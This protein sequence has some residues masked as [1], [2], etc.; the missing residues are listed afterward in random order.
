MRLRM[1]GRLTVAIDCPEA[2]RAQPFPPLLLLSLV[3]NAIKHGVEPKPGPVTVRVDVR[4]EAGRLIVR[5]I[6]DGVGLAASTTGGG[7][8]L[9]NIREHLRTRHGQEASLDLQSR[10]EGGT[11]ATMILPITTA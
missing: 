5:V 3:E 4:A 2:L 10:A 6:D 9:A 11:V 7:V 8:G 1:G